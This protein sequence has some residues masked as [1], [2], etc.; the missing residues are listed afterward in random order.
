[1]PGFPTQTASVFRR[2][3]PRSSIQNSP[4]LEAEHVPNGLQV[5]PTGH[6]RLSSSVRRPLTCSHNHGTLFTVQTAAQLFQEKLRNFL[7]R[8]D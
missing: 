4:L 6:E 5:K 7:Q 8:L 3:E 1:M 2:A